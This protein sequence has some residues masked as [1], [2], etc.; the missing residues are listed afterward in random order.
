MKE[1]RF[2]KTLQLFILTLFLY[3]FAS[4]VFA[5][6]TVT[7]MH[8]DALGSVVA[9]SDE[10]GDLKFRK[11]YRPFGSLIAGSDESEQLSFTGK[12]YDKETNLS[13]FGARNY[14]A[15]LGR[16]TGIDPVGARD[17]IDSN[18]V[19]FN[20]YSYANN[21]PYLYIDPDGRYIEAAFEAASLAFGVDSFARNVSAGS[22]GAASLDAGGIVVDV[23]GAIFPFV[24]GVSGL[25][26]KASREG[27]ELAAK[28][29]TTTLYRAVGP[30]EL[31]DIN[32]TGQVINKGSAEGKYFTNSAEQASSY[33]KQAVNAFG[34]APYTTIKVDVP[35]S[36]LPNPVSVDGG[37]PAYV[38]PNE[39]LKGLK[40]QV[41]DSSA[42]P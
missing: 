16:F 14:D 32:K 24:P 23:V 12:S 3:G 40:P 1:H 27:S 42:V 19:I 11:Q 28:D 2:L 29:G 5:E 7:Y 31:A 25:A 33:A 13:Y 9:G 6:R 30:D 17:R 22:Y 18:P 20:R 21:N 15:M 10:N 41:L 37:I 35:T 26:I 8:T 38:I 36:S 4:A 34:D 39:S